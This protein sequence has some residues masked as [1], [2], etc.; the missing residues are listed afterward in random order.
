MQPIKIPIVF[1]PPLSINSACEF[2][3]LFFAGAGNKR[4]FLSIGK[5]NLGDIE[6]CISFRILK[7]QLRN[8]YQALLL[9]P[10]LCGAPAAKTQLFCTTRCQI[11]PQCARKHSRLPYLWAKTRRKYLRSWYIKSG[12]QK[13]S[14]HFYQ[15]L[16]YFCRKRAQKIQNPR[17]LVTLSPLKP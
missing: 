12:F 13:S 3:K 16:A 2:I 1:S 9:D 17:G 14:W 5:P 7:P 11:S 8:M 15:D 10:A 6:L 4:Y